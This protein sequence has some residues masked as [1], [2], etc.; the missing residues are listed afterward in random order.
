MIQSNEE[1]ENVD[2]LCNISFNLGEEIKRRKISE[3]KIKECIKNTNFDAQDQL[4]IDAY[5]FPDLINPK[6][7]HS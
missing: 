5:I 1:I 6:I 2:E 4:M 3:S 7:C